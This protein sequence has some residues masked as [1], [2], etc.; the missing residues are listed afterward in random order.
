MGLERGQYALATPNKTNPNAAARTP[1]ALLATSSS[2]GVT[3][4]HLIITGRNGA[5]EMP[6]QRSIEEDLFVGWLVGTL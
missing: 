6:N 3:R 4:L 5:S 1:R 2:L